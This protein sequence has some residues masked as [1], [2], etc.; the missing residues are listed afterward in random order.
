MKSLIN[1][2]IIAL[3]LSGFL[4]CKKYLEAKSNQSLSTPSTLNDL[5]Q[6]LDNPQLSN[7]L[8]MDNTATDE[9]YLDEFMWDAQGELYKDGYI[10]KSS[11]N[12][13]DDWASQYSAVFNANTVLYNLDKINSS[14]TDTKQKLKGA[15]L[16]VRAHAFYQIAKLYAPQYDASTATTDLGIPLRLTADFN[17]QSVRSTVQ[18]TYDRIIQDLQEALTLLPD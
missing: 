4:S 12:D 5:Q 13:F 9:I 2:L 3:I 6:I 15:A 11:L 1:L 10:W 17:G 18:Q 7:G 16:F 8:I 14:N